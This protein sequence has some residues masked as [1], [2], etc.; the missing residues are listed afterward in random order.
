[1]GGKCQWQ[2]QWEN[3]LLE[4]YLGWILKPLNLICD[5]ELTQI[6][7]EIQR[8]LGRKFDWRFLLSLIKMNAH[9]VN[10]LSKNRGLTSDV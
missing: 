2:I 9:D 4:S 6:T 7:T 10:Y 1:M 8:R 3:D 5:Q